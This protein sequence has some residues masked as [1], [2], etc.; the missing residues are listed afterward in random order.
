[1]KKSLTMVLGMFLFVSTV[2]S[3]FATSLEEADALYASRAYSV[4][5]VNSAKSAAIAYGELAVAAEDKVEKAELGIKQ[6]GAFYFAGDASVASSERIN[7]FL[8][9][10]DAALK[11]ASYLEKSEGVVADEENT[12]VLAR[13]YFWF[14]ANLARWGEA[15][16]ILSSLGQL[17]TLYKYTGY[18]SEMGQDQVDMYGI[19]RV[20]GRV[21]FKLPFP[22]GSNKKAL[23]YYE[24]A[25]DRSLCD[26]GDISA[27]GL[28]VIFYAEVLIAVGGEENKAKA[29]SILNAF[30]SKGASMDSLM[31][32]NPDR[33]PE[34]LKEI[35]DAKNM[36]K[37]I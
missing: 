29:R 6:S 3:A 35:E 30:V 8:L 27:H 14:S 5:G 36:L 2:A 21:A 19:N 31:A 22:M 26:D 20:L 25:F 34:T 12:E 28:N 4:P 15:N 13:A 24:E 11:A 10:K 1:M 7:Y 37:N 23:A 33:I 16:G 17:P 9:G 18:V 32:Y